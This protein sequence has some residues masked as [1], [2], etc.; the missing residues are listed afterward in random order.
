MYYVSGIKYSLLIVSQIL[1]KWKKV[2][3]LSDCRTGTNIQ[4][5]KVIHK[6]K[7]CKNI[8]YA[9]LDSVP[10]NGLTCLNVQ[11]KN[12]DLGHKKIGHFCSSMLNKL[13]LKDLVV[14]SVPK[15]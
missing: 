9:N 4:S 3:F 7:R 5:S 15:F 13:V 12:I 10:G 2:K 14:H 8:C 11:S 6:D 1:D